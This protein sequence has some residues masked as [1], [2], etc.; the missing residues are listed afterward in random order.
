MTPISTDTL[1]V[2]N[3]REGSGVALPM[4]G[5]VGQ[6]AIGA[7]QKGLKQIALYSLLGG[8]AILFVFPFVW[9]FLTSVKSTT[10]VFDEGVMLPAVWRFDNY[11]LA[12]QSYNLLLYLF[13]STFVSV[14]VAVAHLILATTAGYA[15]ARLH[16]P[17]RNLLFA[18]VIATLMVPSQATLVPLFIL[19]KQW[20]LLGGNDIWGRGG[21]GMLD[22]YWAL[23]VPLFATAY[24]TFLLRQFF[25]TLPADLEDAARIDGTSEFGIYWRI[26]LP[27]SGPA[28]ATLSIFSFQNV[29]NDFVWPL[30]IARSEE[31][32]TIQ[33]GLA[34]FRREGTTEW[35]LLM[36]GTMIATIPI[37]IVF[38]LGQRYFTQGIA[39]TGIKG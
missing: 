4:R 33:V 9:S 8:L 25:L 37:L 12:I 14:I 28:L 39:L 30:V 27:L 7:V 23:T 24:G 38:M 5:R 20:P 31:I 15:F 22:S 32:K 10:E 11:L 1:T 35:T 18:A 2:I 6:A 13:N 19:V 21:F 26:V 29:F 36:A 16:F 34:Q 3:Q 17:G